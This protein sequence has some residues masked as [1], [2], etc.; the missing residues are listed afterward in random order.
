MNG[1]SVQ[2]LGQ[3]PEKTEAPSVLTYGLL[4]GGA[5]LIYSALKRPERPSSKTEWM[6]GAGMAILGL[7]S[8]LGKPK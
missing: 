3:P 5:Y 8:L 7:G 4:G 1:L 2:H 6:I